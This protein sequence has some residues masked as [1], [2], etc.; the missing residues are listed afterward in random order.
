MPSTVSERIRIADQTCHRPGCLH[1]IE[2]V[3]IHTVVYDQPEDLWPSEATGSPV[4]LSEIGRFA[5]S[6][7]D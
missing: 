7:H 4:T 5:C 3:V 1:E 2:Y 6:T